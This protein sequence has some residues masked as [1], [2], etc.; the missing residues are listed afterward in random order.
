MTASKTRDGFDKGN[1]AK[2]CPIFL[3]HGYVKSILMY[4]SNTGVLRW[5][6][7][8]SGV[9]RKS[10]R[11]GCQRNTKYRIVTIDGKQYQEPRIIWFWMTGEDP[12]NHDI[13]HKDRNPSNNRWKNL[14]LASGGQN[15]INT[16]KT[17]GYRK[18]KYG[19]E[20][21]IGTNP[22]I[23]RYAPNEEAAKKIRKQLEKELY[24]EF[25]P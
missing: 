11:A 24:G 9:S 23:V 10:R 19:W 7:S 12:G 18:C 3:S 14:R 4:N 2:Y 20:V 21:Y 22:R 5:K 25:A 8:R 13:D 1:G 16:T 17:K 15:H 6:I